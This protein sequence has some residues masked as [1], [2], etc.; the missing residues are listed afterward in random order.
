MTHWR[1]DW[2]LS[3]DIL[4]DKKEGFVTP[5]PFNTCD[6]ALVMLLFVKNDS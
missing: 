4:P 3:G 1:L 5:R 6:C 2:G